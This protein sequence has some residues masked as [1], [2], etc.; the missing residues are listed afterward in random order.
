MD[1]GRDEG[2]S[3]DGNE[4]AIGSVADAAATYAPISASGKMCGIGNETAAPAA[5]ESGALCA[6]LQNKWTGG[7]VAGGHGTRGFRK[8]G[9]RGMAVA[10]KGLRYP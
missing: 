1:E 8:T 5:V 4:T 10:G 6:R 9:G 2:L 7:G 3:T